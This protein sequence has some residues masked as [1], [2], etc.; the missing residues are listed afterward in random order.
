[1][2]SDKND[3]YLSP[4]R[5]DR[6]K[7]DNDPV[8]NASKCHKDNSFMKEQ[9]ILWRLMDKNVLTWSMMHRQNM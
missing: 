7:K 9:L 2:E 1:M 4:E 8:H 5:N 6:N 3:E